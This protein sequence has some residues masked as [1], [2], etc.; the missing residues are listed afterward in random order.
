ME[1]QGLTIPWFPWF[2]LDPWSWSWYNGSM[3]KR[4]LL[5]IVVILYGFCGILALATC[6]IIV[7]EIFS[8]FS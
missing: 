7:S 3:E 4:E 8:L 1:W 6:G 2:V 5:P